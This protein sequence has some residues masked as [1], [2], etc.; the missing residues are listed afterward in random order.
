MINGFTGPVA[1]HHLQRG[2][3]SAATSIILKEVRKNSVCL[4]CN[5]Y[6]ALMPPMTKSE[7]SRQAIHIW[8]IPQ[9]ASGFHIAAKVSVRI[10]RLLINS[11]PTGV[12]IQELAAI[13]QKA[14]SEPPKATMQVAKRCMPGRDPFPAK[15][16]DSQKSGLQHKGHRCLKA[17]QMAEDIAARPGKSTPVGAELKFHGDTADHPHG[18]IEQKQAH[19]ETGM[20]IITLVSLV[21]SQRASITTRKMLSPMV[22]TGQ[23]I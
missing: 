10:K 6:Q 13:I 12:C 7:I 9:K 23:M 14:D 2:D 3:K 21:I 19:P 8:V 16:H 5:R 1:D 22:R 11:P 20:M 15:S 18:K 4:P 17:E